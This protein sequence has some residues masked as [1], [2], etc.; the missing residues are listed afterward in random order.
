MPAPVATAPSP[1]ATPAVLTPPSVS[2]EPPVFLVLLPTSPPR[3]AVVSAL[4]AG[5]GAVTAPPPPAE[6]A[7]RAA[8]PSSAGPPARTAPA[9]PGAPTATAVR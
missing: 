7:R 6:P 9:A 3:P 4:P 2:P 1:S 5:Q 8:A